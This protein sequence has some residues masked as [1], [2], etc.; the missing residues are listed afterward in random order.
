MTEAVKIS[1]A[2][3]KGDVGRQSRRAV[4]KIVGQVAA[5]GKREVQNDLTKGHGRDE[6]KYRRGIRRKTKGLTALVWAS[7]G[8]I[9]AWLEGTSKRNRTTKFK[10]FRIFANARTRTD[11]KAGN[12][13]RR[14]VAELVRLLGGRG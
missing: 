1:G 6:G 8:M 14:G 11:K 13:A 7:N 10:G 12:E 9:A 3:F 5:V 4:S 2:F